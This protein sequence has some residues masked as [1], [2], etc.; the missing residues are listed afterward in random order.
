MEIVDRLPITQD[1]SVVILK[2]EKH[3]YLLSLSPNGIGL[4][5][6]LDDM[7]EEMFQTP[8]HFSAY[9]EHDFKDVLSQYFVNRKK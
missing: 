7:D 9:K 8:E 2:V 6:E 5:K 1:K 4:I 3:Y